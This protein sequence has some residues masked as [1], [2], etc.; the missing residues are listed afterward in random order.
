[1]V[2]AQNVSYIVTSWTD[3]QVSRC[4]LDLASEVVSR[5]IIGRFGCKSIHWTNS[6]LKKKRE[7]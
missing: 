3:K 7:D 5:T 6:T 2:G 4:F 1:M